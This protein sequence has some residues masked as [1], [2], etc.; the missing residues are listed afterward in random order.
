M[1]FFGFCVELYQIWLF[2]CFFFVP[3]QKNKIN[4]WVPKHLQLQ[5]FSERRVAFSD[6]IARVPIFLAMTVYVQLIVSLY[7]SHK[8]NCEY[9]YKLPFN[10]QSRI[11]MA[12][13]KTYKRKRKPNWTQEQLLLLAQ[14]VNENKDIIKWKFGDGIT[15]KPKVI[16]F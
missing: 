2:F 15:A 1:H 14:L 9:A 4:M 8:K 11:I 10:K 7:A 16:P 3:M 6:R 13:S 12:D 5:Q